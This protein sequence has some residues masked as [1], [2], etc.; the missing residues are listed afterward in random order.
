M[1]EQAI[2]TRAI[3][4]ARLGEEIRRPAHRFHAAGDD[5]V[6]ASRG[7]QVVGEH[8]CF[9]ARAADLVDRRS[10]GGVGQPRAAHRLSRRRLSLARL[11]HVAHENF[12]D[13]LRLHPS[14]RHRRLDGVRAERMRR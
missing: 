14:P 2:V 11:E 3:A 13:V 12:I 8:R 10:A 5:Y 6:C 4:A 7:D 9:H 1:V